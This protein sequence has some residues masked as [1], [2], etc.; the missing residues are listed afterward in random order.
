MLCKSIFKSELFYIRNVNKTNIYICLY[1][2]KLVKLGF[3]DLA[4]V[5][6]AN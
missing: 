2:Y 1:A 3:N 4:E 6:D 5:S